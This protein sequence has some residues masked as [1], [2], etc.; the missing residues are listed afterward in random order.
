MNTCQTK[1]R[2]FRQVPTLRSTFLKELKFMDFYRWLLKT[3]CSFVM[4]LTYQH[5]VCPVLFSFYLFKLKISPFTEVRFNQFIFMDKTSPSGFQPRIPPL[6]LTLGVLV[7]LFWYALPFWQLKM[8]GSSKVYDRKWYSISFK[9]LCYTWVDNQTI[10]FLKKKLTKTF[11]ITRNMQTSG[12]TIM[13][14]LF[15]VPRVSS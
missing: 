5:R 9:V 4:F 7:P 3:D 12:L 13:L 6:D 10:C 14:S 8:S 15:Q 1:E 2:E 11:D